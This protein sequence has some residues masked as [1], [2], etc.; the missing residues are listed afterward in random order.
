[1]RKIKSEEDIEKARR[2]NNIILGLVMIFLL[3]ASS[4]GYS[5]MSA[6]LEKKN[7]VNENGYDFVR[8]GGY[9]KTE[10]NGEVFAFSNLPSDLAGIDVELGI[11]LNEYDGKVIYFVNSKEGLGRILGNIG[12]HILRY[13]EACLNLSGVGGQELA[14]KE[15]RSDL[16]VKDCSSN[17]IIFEEG[18]ETRVYGQDNCVFI[19]GD[20]SRGSEA[21]LYKL[22]GIN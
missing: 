11:S 9:W 13:Q 7:S 2:R 17:L 4:L 15:C 19:V 10:I 8:D 22:I 16:P 5:L 3:T 21:F 14:T 18:N 20:D 12:G 6:D 1:M